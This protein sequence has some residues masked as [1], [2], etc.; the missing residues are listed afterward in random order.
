[1]KRLRPEQ[2]R[3]ALFLSAILEHCLLT[4]ENAPMKATL[5]T[6]SY[7][8]GIPAPIILRLA[9]LHQHPDDLP[10]IQ[11]E[12]YH[13]LFANLQFRFPTLCL[14]ETDDGGVVAVL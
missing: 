10:N 2:I 14:Y 3:D 12:D 13:F 7:D 9:Q 5:R 6:L 4:L 8:T 1:M 11:P